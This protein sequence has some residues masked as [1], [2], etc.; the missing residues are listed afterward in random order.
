M[1][2]F[3]ERT[4]N[5]CC[6]DRGNCI[7]EHLPTLYEYAKKSTHVT[8]CGV[9][10][11]PS[12]WSFLKGLQENGQTEKRLVSADLN[13]HSNISKVK[14]TARQVGVSYLFMQGND[15]FLEFEETDLLFIDTWHVY[16]HL[17]RE[18]EKLH[19]FARKW[20]IL[21]DTTVDGE[22]GETLRRGWNAAKQSEE[23]DIPI[24]EITRGIWP[25]VEEF[26]ENHKDQWKLLERRVNC[27]GLTILERTTTA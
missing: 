12:S 15:L 8:E 19:V 13:Y 7:N 6:E 27:N 22:R 18:L 26:L 9:E 2:D 20:I 10:T 24:E 4:Y 17:K 1:S 3:L 25:A 23:T 16:G 5:S 14:R 21:H 11:C